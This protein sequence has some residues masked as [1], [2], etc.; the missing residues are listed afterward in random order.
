VPNAVEEF[1][2][3]DPPSH[4]QGRTLTEAVTLH[5]ERM[6]EGARVMIINGASGRDPRRF[7][8]PDRLD[9][10]REIDLVGETLNR[11]VSVVEH[12]TTTDRRRR[13]QLPRHRDHRPPEH[14]PTPVGPAKVLDT[15][16]PA[17]VE[18]SLESG[19]LL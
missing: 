6:P 1:L 19:D 2:R 4:Y 5:G 8:D 17:P 11:P 7:D 9:V 16:L 3:F 15:V 18:Q 14:D 13:L 12:S 10:T